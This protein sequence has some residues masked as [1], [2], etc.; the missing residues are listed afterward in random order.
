MSPEP[1]GEWAEGGWQTQGEW[2]HLQLVRNI[3]RSRET[4][5][6]GDRAHF[7]LVEAKAGARSAMVWTQ[8][9][10]QRW[11]RSVPR[12]HGTDS[13]GRNIIQSQHL[14]VRSQVSRVEFPWLN[15]GGSWRRRNTDVKYTSAYSQR[16]G[17][18]KP[19]A[20]CLGLSNLD[21]GKNKPLLSLNKLIARKLL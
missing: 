15:P 13:L 21:H 16:I 5:K 6:Y 12:F 20:C 11:T 4:R 19:V 8:P 1:L 3:W 10:L 17:W 14:E 2:K 9:V 18:D 7:G